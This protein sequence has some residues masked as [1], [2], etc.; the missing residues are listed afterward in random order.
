MAKPAPKF[1]K[2]G[3]RAKLEPRREPYWNYVAS[4]GY[5]GY[6]RTLTG[7][8]WIARYRRDNGKQEYNALK[9]P[10]SVPEDEA[11]DVAQRMALK[12]FED[13]ARGAV[14]QGSGG[15][16]VSDA[17]TAYVASLRA[18]KGDS[19]ANDA[20]GRINLKIQSSPLWGKRVD[21]LTR[22]DIEEWRNAQVP[23]GADEETTRKAKDTANRNLTVL[24]ALLN[25][26]WKSDRVAQ[27]GPWAKVSP[28][29][30]VA[31]S[32]RVFLTL[33]QRRRLLEHTDG[34]FRDLLEAAMLTGARY[35]ELRQ[36]KAEDFDKAARRLEIHK[37]KTGVRTVA[38]SD[39]AHTFFARVSKEKLPG[40][41]LLPRPD[42]QPWA[43]SDQDELMRAAVKASRLPKETVF[44]TLRHTFIATALKGGIDIASIAKNCGTSVR[45]I[46]RNYAKFIPED[47]GEQLNKV[48]LV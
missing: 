44:Y 46:E 45:I 5:L 42:G 40:A 26:A 10:L 8:S 34:A 31:K 38:L 18:R 39:A 22:G 23:A 37:G 29:P 47:V 11:R 41:A 25:H 17:A 13:C 24:K 28:F 12:W 30:N 9:L 20:Q 32:R 1:A 35:G 19:A 15:Y 2:P 48:A 16:K 43:H 7:G 4:R 36:L 14:Q 21:R 3:D 6:R 27:P 33:E